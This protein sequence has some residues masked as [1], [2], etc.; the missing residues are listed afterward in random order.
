LEGDTLEYS[1]F[2]EV[3]VRDFYE[4]RDDTPATSKEN[5]DYSDYHH[6][7]SRCFALFGGLFLFYH[8]RRRQQNASKENL[9]VGGASNEDLTAA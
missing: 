6:L 3:D 2:Q 4:T 5:W 9:T 1:R 7:H 8:R